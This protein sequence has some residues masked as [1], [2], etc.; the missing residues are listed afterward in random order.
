ME[1]TAWVERTRSERGVTLI[2]TFGGVTT[3]VRA[4]ARKDSSFTLY[5]P[6]KV[7]RNLRYV[8]SQNIPEPSENERVKYTRFQTL[9]LITSGVLEH[10]W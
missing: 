7:S 3:R 8:Q 4:W 9:Y 6:S 10:K 5:F 2:G 1:L